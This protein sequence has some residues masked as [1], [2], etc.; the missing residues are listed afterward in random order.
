MFTTEKA[1]S[2]LRASGHRVEQY[3]DLYLIDGGAYLN[4]RHKTEASYHRRSKRREFGTPKVHW[5]RYV[6]LAREGRPVY[7]VVIEGK[8]NTVYYARVAD[9]IPHARVYLGV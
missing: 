7:T 4:I 1:I 5:D 8:S 3:Q 6:K 2:H 9:L